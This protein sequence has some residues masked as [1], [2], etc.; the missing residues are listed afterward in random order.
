MPP[1]LVPGHV[2]CVA[3]LGCFE[4]VLT[5]RVARHRRD[6]R[7]T[8]RGPSH[9]RRGTYRRCVPRRPRLEIAGGRFHVT[10]RGVSGDPIFFDDFDYE[11]CQRL[12]ARTVERFS[13]RCLAYCLMPNHLHLV[14]ETPECNRGAGMR[15]FA[16]SYAQR[17]NMRYDRRG[18]VFEA[19]YRVTLV[20][21]Q[22]HLLEA[23]RYVAVNPVRAGLRREPEEWRWSSHAPTAGQAPWPAFLSEE[24]LI[25]FGSE[26]RAA[27]AGYRRFVSDRLLLPDTSADEVPRQ[28]RGGHVCGPGPGTRP[29]EPRPRT[30][31]GD[32]ASASER[33]GT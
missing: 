28:V 31:S 5:L 30:G 23:V 19:P 22:S 13:W 9:R 33:G 27:A 24:V 7:R 16:G 4:Q 3:E 25:F 21:T 15:H 32:M 10:A 8:S 20:E 11:A 1:D 29:N 26:R 6:R 12:L 14:I 2:C 18:H 17:F